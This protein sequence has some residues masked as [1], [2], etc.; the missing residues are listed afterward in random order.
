MSSD[1]PRV[2]PWKS[3]LIAAPALAI[4]LAACGGSAPFDS[5]ET[6]ANGG[7][8]IEDVAAENQALLQP[9]HSAF[10]VEV[11]SVADGSISTLRDVVD[12]DRPVLVWFYAPH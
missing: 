9:A 5:G 3:S 10:D 2:R 11:L 4:T 12:G 8:T 7:P 1:T 6:S